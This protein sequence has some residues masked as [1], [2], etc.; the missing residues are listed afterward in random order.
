MKAH[1]NNENNWKTNWT[2]WSDIEGD[3]KRSLWRNFSYLQDADRE[4]ILAQ[5]AIFFAQGNDP[6]A[7]PTRAN[8]FHYANAC[9]FR[10][11]DTLRKPLFGGQVKVGEEYHE[12]GRQTRV[13]LDAIGELA[14]P[15]R[16]DEAENEFI[17]EIAEASPRAALIIRAMR[18][19]YTRLEIAQKLGV[20]PAQITHDLLAA[21]Q[22]ARRQQGQMTLFTVPQDARKMETRNAAK[23][24]RPTAAASRSSQ[25]LSLFAA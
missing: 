25:Q 12:S 22:K 3:I 19:G 10:A 4:D 15:A 9:L 23:T 5:T 13:D 8:S 17:D 20:T 24:G 16:D 7:F 1:E 11:A 6:V 18:A 21:A 2:I 14:N